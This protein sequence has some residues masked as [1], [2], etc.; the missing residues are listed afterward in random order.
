LRRCDL[1]LELNYLLTLGVSI[2]ELTIS[3]K[4]AKSNHSQDPTTASSSQDL[5]AQELPQNFGK[6]NIK[7]KW[8]RFLPL[9]VTCVLLGA[10]YYYWAF[11]RQAVKP[12]LTELTTP[13]KKQDI[14][15]RFE[16]S[17]TVKPIST[18]NLSPKTTGRLASLY[19]D[20]GDRVKTGEIIALMDSSSLEA[21]LA[22]AQLLQAEAMYEEV[23]NGNRT[24]EISRSR[25]TVKSAQASVDLNSA[26]LKRY[27]MLAQQGAIAPT[28]LDRYISEDRRAR[29]SLE[30]VQQQL[31]ELVNGSR[32][33]QI[34]QAKAQLAAAKAQINII[35]TEV[36]DT[37]IRSPF[38][39]IVTQKYT[40][41]GA[42]VTPTT[43]ASS[44]ASATSTS[45][46][47]L[48]SGLEVLVYVPEAQIARVKQ[49]QRVEIVAVSYPNRIFTG[50][51]KQIAPEA[52]VEN[53][54]TS[55]Q[56]EVDLVDGKS[57]LQSGMNVDVTFIGETIPDALVVPTATISDRNGQMGVTILDE[58]GKTRFQP[59]KVGITQNTQ[60]QVLEGLKAQDKVLL[61]LPEKRASNA[62]N[63]ETQRF[64][65]RN[66]MR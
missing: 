55:F 22:Q 1:N 6:Q 39:G 5:L 3:R 34:K 50:R 20:R 2:I 15:I 33:E 23:V 10:G 30:E 32:P 27:Q 45:I 12:N 44:T 28:E 11:R 31:Q 40:T 43:S 57:E 7:T 38:E 14:E 64:I 29:A 42:I 9:L 51:V 36:N 19:V 4:V 37:I 60:T 16:A 58:D 59:I 52:I 62:N 17:G 53:N 26:Q 25:A 48:A 47:A 49:G 35:Q 56:V 61:A 24:E 54:V 41:V 13:V 46:V 65:Q 63:R 8:L 18:I 21:E 66:L